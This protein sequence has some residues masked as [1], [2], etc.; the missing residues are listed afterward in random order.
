MERGENCIQWLDYFAKSCYTGSSHHKQPEWHRQVPSC[1][2]TF[3]TSASSHHGF[4]PCLW[5]YVLYPDLFCTF[6][7]KMGPKVITSWLYAILAYERF[8][9]NALLSN[10]GGNL[11]IFTGIYLRNCVCKLRTFISFLFSYRSMQHDT[12]PWSQEERGLENVIQI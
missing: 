6:V 7:S 12:G 3:S 2:T 8:P 4:E 9:R 10:S 1:R 11:H 5:A